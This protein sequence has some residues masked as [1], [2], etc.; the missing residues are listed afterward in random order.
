MNEHLT[1]F[2]KG[3]YSVPCVKLNNFK[4][5]HIDL[6]IY[7]KVKRYL[8]SLFVKSVYKTQTIITL[9]YVVVVIRCVSASKLVMFAITKHFR[10]ENSM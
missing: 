9:C 3:A 1:N 5:I 2:F 6:L 4:N 7:L 8:Q 10:F